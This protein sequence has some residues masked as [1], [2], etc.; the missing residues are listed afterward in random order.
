MVV[1]GNRPMRTGDRVGS[2]R[3]GIQESA[4]GRWIIRTVE[5][6]RSVAVDGKTR[7]QEDRVG[8]GE[9]FSKLPSQR[10]EAVALG[11]Y[12]WVQSEKIAVRIFHW[13]KQRA[14]WREEKRFHLDG[15]SQNVAQ[16]VLTERSRLADSSFVP[17]LWTPKM[18][19][20]VE[21]P[22]TAVMV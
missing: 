9:M 19:L 7:Q 5:V 4:G 8:S 6:R 2:V 11:Q 16:A 21:V 1:T 10:R 18:K 13:D 14:N 15:R 3:C 12:G 17:S 22:L 20:V